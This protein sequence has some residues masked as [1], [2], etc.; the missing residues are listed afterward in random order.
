MDGRDEAAGDE[1]EDYAGSE[2][3]FSEAVAQLEVLVEHGAEGEG[4]GLESCLVNFMCAA[5][6][7]KL[8]VGHTSRWM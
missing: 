2:V 6:K 5:R 3:V 7:V 8:F 1:A 4:D